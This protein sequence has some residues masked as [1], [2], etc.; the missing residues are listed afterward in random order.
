MLYLSPGL[1]LT[2][3]EYTHETDLNSTEKLVKTELTLEP[4]SQKIGWNLWTELNHEDCL[5]KQ[6]YQ[7]SSGFPAG[8]MVK[9][10]PNAGDVGSIPG[11]GRYSGE[12]NGNPLQSS[13]LGNPMIEEPGG[14]QSM[15]SQRVGH[16]LVTK[17]KTAINSLYR[18]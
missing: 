12:G 10:L 18:I 2:T 11:L 13:C 7:H 9:N 4:H 15:V 6:M 5:L 1:R 3:G 14:L 16:N 17:T 8:S